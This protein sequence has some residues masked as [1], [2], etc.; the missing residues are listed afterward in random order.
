MHIPKHIVAVGGLVRDGEGRVL[1]GRSV[2][3]RGWEFFGGQVEN[4]ENLEEALLREIREETGITARVVALA[5][6]YSSLKGYTDAHTGVHI[7]T[8]L[9]LDFLCDY[10]SG[11]PTDSDETTD[12]M[13]VTVP[14][15]LEQVDT[16]PYRMRLENMLHHAGRVVYA[17][18]ETHP[19]AARACRAL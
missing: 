16:Q 8:K 1:I 6:I 5:G 13:W 18:Y 4:G 19:F 14:R 15:A 7:P 3:R 9:I 11:T 2:W 17:A 10:V 12:V